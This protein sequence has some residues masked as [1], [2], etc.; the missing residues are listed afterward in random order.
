MNFS[1]VGFEMNPNSHRM[2]GIA[3][4]HST[5]KPAWRTPRSCICVLLTNC[6]CTMSASRQLW[7]WYAYCISENM[8]SD[9]VDPGL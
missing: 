5:R 1:S 2:L 9:S 8:I 6:F 7:V 3:A 4:R